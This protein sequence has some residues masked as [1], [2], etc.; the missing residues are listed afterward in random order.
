MSDMLHKIRRIIGMRVY[1]NDVI[2]LFKQKERLPNGSPA[3]VVPVKNDNV[4][5]ARHFQTQQQVNLFRKFLLAGD[6]GYYAYLDG[7]CVHRSWVVAHPKKAQIHKFYSFPLTPNQVFI[8]YCETAKEARGRNIFAAVLTYIGEVYHD[9]EV[10]MSIEHHNKSSIRS[11][12]KAGF[13][14][15]EKIHVRVTGGVKSIKIEKP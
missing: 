10:L 3:K 6:A 9:K 15:I 1:T 5:D 2:I 14:P 11:A 13:F 12:T 4:E 7:R 8:H